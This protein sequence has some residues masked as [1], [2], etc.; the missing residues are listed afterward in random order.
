[1]DTDI[2]SKGQTQIVKSMVKICLIAK[3]NYLPISS[4]LDA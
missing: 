3:M 1:M 2:A 4:K